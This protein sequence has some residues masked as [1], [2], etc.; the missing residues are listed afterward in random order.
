[1]YVQSNGEI[2]L[3]NFIKIMIELY[4]IGNIEIFVRIDLSL[5]FGN[6]FVVSIVDIILINEMKENSVIKYRKGC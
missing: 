3:C 6:G 5:Y 4:W 2:L 1:M